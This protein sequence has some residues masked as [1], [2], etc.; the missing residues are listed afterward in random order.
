MFNNILGHTEIKK[1]LKEQIL[2]GEVS[3]A[4]TFYG[5]NSV[6]KKTIALEFARE[7]L[8]TKSLDTCP[9][10]KYIEKAEDKTEIIVGQ[11]KKIITE[12]INIV[13]ACSKYKVYVIN[14]A[15]YMNEESQNKLLKTL[16]EP[17]SFVV[18][19]LVTS[20]FDKLL[21]TI[22]SR[23]SNICF[24]RLEDSDIKSLVGENVSENIL[25]YADGSLDK[26]VRS[27]L[28]GAKEKYDSL[29][30]LAERIKIKDK[31]AVIQG[32]KEISMKDDSLDY[33]EHLLIG[34]GN[35]LG[36]TKIEK[37]K[38]NFKDSHTN[39]EIA[40]TILAIELCR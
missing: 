13:P 28:E 27:T 39:E 20:F 23:T 11:I 34:Q 10:Y 31:V 9:D 15:E 5:I 1:Y 22:K 40:K 35:Y 36:I 14:D 16:E 18:I 2:A 21:P 6:G 25:K 4:Y 24:S 26:V 29:D 37:A 32:L 19:I 12:D 30:V 8:K 33:L 3:H 17:P 38:K 7:L